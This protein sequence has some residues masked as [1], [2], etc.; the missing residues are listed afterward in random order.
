[1]ARVLG[2]PAGTHR[3]ALVGY[4]LAVHGIRGRRDGVAAAWPE[5]LRAEPTSPFIAWLLVSLGL[6]ATWTFLGVLGAVTGQT[7]RPLALVAVPFAAA[8]AGGLTQAGYRT[9]GRSARRL[10]RGASPPGQPVLP[11]GLLLPC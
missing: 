3:S 8:A 6:L 1:M 10:M 11:G 2:R 7:A 5:L 4:V 9:P